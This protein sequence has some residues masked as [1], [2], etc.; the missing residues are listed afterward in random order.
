MEPHITETG[1]GIKE[2]T[3]LDAVW[4][5]LF[6]AISLFFSLR[7]FG[8]DSSYG[9]N[10]IA[11][12]LAACVALL[13]G[14]K[15]G[16]KWSALEEGVFHNMSIIFGPSFILLAVGIMIATW[17]AGGVVPSMIY[18]GL[19]LMNPGIFYA[20][21]CLICAIVS[22]SIG[23]SWTTAASVGVAMI[24][25]AVGLGL[26]PAICAGA[27]ISGAYFGDK[28]SPLS[29]T[30]NLAPAVAGVDLFSHIR[31][32]AWTG[33]PALVL[34]LVIF[35][36]IGLTV[37]V[38]AGGNDLEAT[39]ATLQANYTIGWY[40]LL[41]LATLFIL[42]WKKVPALPAILIAA[43]LGI[44]C[45]VL[46]QESVTVESGNGS[47]V[48]ALWQIL[49]AGYTATTGDAIL[50]D[51]LSGGGAA[52][53]LNTIWLIMCAVFF[54]GAMEE[55]GLL[56]KILREVMKRAKTSASIITSTILTCIGT[57]IIA[58]DQYI[59]IVLPGR[60]YKVAFRHHGLAPVNLSRAIEDSAT[61]TSALIPWNTC[62][63]F[64]A[65]SLGVPTLVYL[66]FCFFNL[67]MPVISIF[68]GITNFR[69]VPLDEKIPDN[70]V[71]ES[72]AQR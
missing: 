44:V 32:M 21:T 10:Q 57:N 22:L 69:I 40:L 37:E 8:E 19:E 70:A 39:L 46:F 5:V 26:S 7:F 67:S 38:Q 12:L 49:F 31:H 43:C 66:P 2:A 33:V 15:N 18:Y 59:G 3:L 61:V 30:T 11:L 47:M 28:M 35:S 58:G 51:L 72:V 14:F 63:A 50:D 29:D 62:G 1:E 9:P 36:L 41:P 20:A 56:T 54:G 6:L 16:H 45:A 52:N 13:V 34:S 55:T 60:M 25:T 65:A 53:M 27:I 68:Y 48:A 4:P 17:I 23:S 71:A 24:G 42:A 64:M